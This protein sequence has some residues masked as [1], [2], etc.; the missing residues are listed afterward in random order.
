VTISTRSTIPSLDGPDR[1][2]VGTVAEQPSSPRRP[3]QDSSA[4]ARRDRYIDTLR[5][6]ALLRVIL[7]HT[8]GFAWLPFLFPSMGIMFALAGGLVAASLDRHNTIRGR[9]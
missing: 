2:T 1:Q 6:G 7:Y 8:F 4:G 9:S 5:A 3:R